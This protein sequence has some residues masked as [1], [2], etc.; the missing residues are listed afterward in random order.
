MSNKIS[1]VTG[2]MG[3]GGAE[4]V[5]SLL[6]TYYAEKG[7]TVEIVMLL[8]SYLGY[9]LHDKVKVFDCSYPGGIR[10]GFLQTIVKVRKHFKDSKPDIIVCFMAQNCLLTGLA[11][12]GFKRNIIMSERIDPSKVQRNIVYKKI[13][14]YFYLHANK[15]VFQTKRAMKYFPQTIQDNGCI[16]GNP[17]NVNYYKQ[18][19][20]TVNTHRIVTA[21]RM[22]E[23][24][25][26]AM[27]IEAFAEINKY[28]PEYTLTIYGEGVLRKK[29]EALSDSLGLNE[30]VDFPGNVP[31]L[32]KKI[33]DAEIFVLPSN[34]EGLSNALLEAMMIGLPVIATNCAGCDEVIQNGKNGIL[35]DVGDK[36]ALIDALKQLIE[37]KE[38]R[39]QIAEAGK[40]SV[41]NFK[42][43][44]IIHKWDKLITD[45]MM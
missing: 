15:V 43:E 20:Q 44:N 8:H 18:S 12:L 3:R 42:T 7:W 24:K 32:H 23:Q 16:I 17:V 27:L 35:I 38:Y 30:V 36:K 4:R 28:Y 25:N 2:S 26:Q 14:E 45:C 29:L 34:F 37:K 11:L 33:S 21:G 13:L 5:I 10:K 9:E 31:D 1:F 19:I 41:Q 22:T 6:S 40:M 39:L